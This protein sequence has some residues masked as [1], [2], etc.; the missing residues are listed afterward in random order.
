MHACTCVCVY[1]CMCVRVRMHVRVYVLE[2][3]AHDLQL[4][5]A[6]LYLTT[7]ILVALICHYCFV[8]AA[9]FAMVGFAVGMSMME[10]IKTLSGGG[11]TP[12]IGYSAGLAIVRYVRM[13]AETTKAECVQKGLPLP[14]A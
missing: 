4:F 3:V 7:G 11:F 2:L 12:S 8:V 1:V 14:Q 9:L 6:L 13:G 5:S 10:S